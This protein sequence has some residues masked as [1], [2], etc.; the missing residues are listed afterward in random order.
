MFTLYTDQIPQSW[1]A[2]YRH[3]KKVGQPK[4]DDT[5][6]YVTPPTLAV[7]VLVLNESALSSS[8][9]VSLSD[10]IV[11]GED[12]DPILHGPPTSH[13][14]SIDRKPKTKH[15]EQEKEERAHVQLRVQARNHLLCKRK[16]KKGGKLAQEVCEMGEER[17]LG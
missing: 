4:Q 1:M 11:P 13:E 8:V 6:K 9:T 16:G 14:S 10:I 15:T 17:I 3:L 7:D 5:N 2:M 12:N